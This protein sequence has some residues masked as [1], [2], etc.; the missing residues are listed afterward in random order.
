MPA[1]AALPSPVA[2]AYVVSSA[3]IGS[4]VA[5]GPV[6]VSDYPPGGT[7]TQAG[8]NAGPF[9]TSST[10]TAITAGDP[11]A[12]TSSASATVQTIDAN[13]GSIGAMSLVGVRSTCN[14]T[15]NGATGSGVISS[16]QATVPAQSPVALQANAAP[17]TV[18]NV[19]NLGTVTLNEQT[20]DPNGILTV[21]AVHLKLLQQFNSADVI[22][23]HVQCGGAAPAPTVTKTTAQEDSFVLGQTLHYTVTVRNNGT[24]PLTNLQVTDNGPGSPTVTCPAGPLVPGATVPC[25]ATY[26]AT[27]ADVAAGR[28]VDTATVTATL[29]DGGVVTSTSPQLVVPLRA[30]TITK[31]PTEADFHGAGQTLHYTYT[32][33]NTGQAQINNVTVTDLTPGVNVSGCGTNQLAPGQSTTCQATYVTTAADVQA[34][35]VTDQGSVT[36]TT[37]GGASVSATSNQVSTLLTARAGLSARLSVSERR[38]SRAGQQ[39]HVSLRITNTGGLPISSLQAAVGSLALS[40]PTTTLAPGASVTCTAIYTTTS[41]DVSAGRIAFVVGVTGTASDGT[42]VTVT[43]N[44]V[45]I[46]RDPCGDDRRSDGCRDDKHSGKDPK[47]KPGKGHRAMY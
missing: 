45:T 41:A 38:F 14:A 17:N 40:C 5:V 47:K 19:P 6:P 8:I 22:V 3:A 31:K 29:P 20:T 7:T 18:V 9:L 21:N 13:F 30:L 15:P 44:R 39:L 32:V 26:T 33:T 2:H 25:T 42:A 4:I 37:P 23:G 43:S 10:L 34:G 16:G 12:G 27:A 36:A 11:A 46:L 1:H 28:I 35:S 24:E